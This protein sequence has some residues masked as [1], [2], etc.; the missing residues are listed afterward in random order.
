MKNEGL[1]TRLGECVGERH[2]LTQAD[3]VAPF[4]TD[5]RG[6][7]TGSAHAVVRPADTS[8]VSA[9]LRLCHD[10]GVGVV[11][12]GGNTGLCGGATPRQGE[13]AIVLALDR[14]NLI[15]RIDP[16][17]STLVADAGCT[18]AQIQRAAAD[19]DRL[20]PMSLASE[21]S[22]QIGGNIAT[23]AGGVHV[24][25]YGNMR[26]QVLGLEVVLPDGTVW[27]G[28]RTLLKDNTGYDLKQLFIGSEGTLGVITAAALRLVPRPRQ[29]VVAWLAVSSPAAALSL[30]AAARDRLGERVSAFELISRNALDVVLRH[31]PGARAPLSR[32][33]DWSVLLEVADVAQEAPLDAILERL[34]G[35]AFEAGWVVDAAV[36]T[37][38]AQCDALW[39][40]RESISEAQRIEGVSIKHDVSLPVS[41]I[42]AFLAS[43]ERALAER[44]PWVR[45]VAFGHM[46]DGN[47]H[48]NISA[49][50]AARNEV[51]VAQ[52]EVVNRCVHDLVAG[53]DG[54]ISAEH[55]IGQLKREEIARYKP[56]IE[57]ELMRAIKRAVDPH[58]VMNPGK[59]L[60]GMQSF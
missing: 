1:L 30:L 26:Q 23:N 3:D 18:L 20:F 44:F 51:L 46:G 34:A 19:V 38:I 49:E 43:A 59:V 36:A 25:R 2:V 40:L 48:Y 56:E 28:L 22:C 35:D 50:D 27:N 16:V 37:S 42:P 11:P 13:N 24:V 10:L 15:R 14:L 41:G 39:A 12:Q 32:S 6:R 45:I 52:T 5:W 33:S 21:G 54:S 17:D 60:P 57:L 31:I 4:L 47:L 58:D 9:V 7:Y 29:R 55:G 8:Q 53:F